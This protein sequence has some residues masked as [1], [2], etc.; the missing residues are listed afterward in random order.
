M[1]Y[2]K[3]VFHKTLPITPNHQLQL[4]PTAH[5]NFMLGSLNFPLGFLTEL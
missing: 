3:S 5:L 1:V 4:T 2:L